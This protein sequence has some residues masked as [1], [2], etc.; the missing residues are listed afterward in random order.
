MEYIHVVTLPPWQLR[1]SKQKILDIKTPPIL[2]PEPSIDL[3]VLSPIR[4]MNIKFNKGSCTYY[5][6]TDRGGGVSPN[7]YSIT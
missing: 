6:I 3:W 4:I 5:V 2:I 7:D 1:S